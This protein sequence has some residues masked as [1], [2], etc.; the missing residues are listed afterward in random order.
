MTEAVPAPSPWRARFAH[1]AGRGLFEVLYAV[2]QHGARHVPTTGPVILAANHTGYLD[3]ALVLSMSPRASHFLVL[4]QTFDG[5][6]GTLLEL[7]GQIPI[8]Q[9]VGDR[10]A[11]GQALEVLGR[12]G[13]VG[14]FPEGGRG[15]G[16]LANAGRGVAWLAIQGRATVV[17]TACLGTRA[18]GDHAD[19][20]PRLRSRMVVDFGP[21]VDLDLPEGVPG[22]QRL[23]HAAE[24]IRATLGAHV[25]D[26]SRRHGIPL[27]DDIPEGLVGG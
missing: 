4:A 16:D 1:V 2:E 3:G 24:Q 25:L 7:T 13:V 22:R 21:P 8:D 20:W 19:S 12:G 26:A 6:A 18:T 11:L 23:L 5:P 15:R 17:P 9:Q 14:I 10:R 27:P